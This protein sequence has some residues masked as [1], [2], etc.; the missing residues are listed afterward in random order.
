MCAIQNAF[1]VNWWA[2]C[3]ETCKRIKIMRIILVG[4]VSVSVCVCTLCMDSFH[5]DYDGSCAI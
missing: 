1:V 3:G 2:D 4:N 5:Q